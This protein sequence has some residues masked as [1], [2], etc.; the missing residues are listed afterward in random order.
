M[1]YSS[2]NI[3]VKF[4]SGVPESVIKQIIN[5]N[6]SVVIDSIP[7]LNVKVVKIP[8]G[9]TVKEAINLFLESEYVEYAEVDEFIDLVD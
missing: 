5:D 2:E 1:N 6:D 4:K 3:I 9:K 7:Q 8:Q